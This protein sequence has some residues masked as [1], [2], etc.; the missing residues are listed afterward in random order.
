MVKKTTKKVDPVT[1]ELIKNTMVAAV[2]EASTL[3]ERVAYHPVA[4]LGRDRTSGLLTPEG[5]LICHGHSD[6]APHYG[7]LELCS[8]ELLKDVPA[9]TM[10]Y[11]NES[12]P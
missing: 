11:S 3:L 6:C 5:N 12:G 10:K 9:S 2:H 1:F 8:K 4:N 7:T